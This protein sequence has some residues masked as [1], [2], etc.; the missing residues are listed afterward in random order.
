MGI[1]GFPFKWGCPPKSS[2]LTRFSITKTIQRAWGSPIFRA[3]NLQLETLVRCFFWTPRK[4]RTYHRH[5][6]KKCWTSKNQLNAFTNWGT[7]RYISPINT[8]I[9]ALRK[10]NWTRSRT[11]APLVNPIV[12]LEFLVAPFTNRSRFCCYM[13]PCPE[14]AWPHTFFW[15][16]LAAIGAGRAPV[17]E[18]VRRKVRPGHFWFIDTWGICI[19]K[20]TKTNKNQ[21]ADDLSLWLYGGFLKIGVPQSWMV[22][23]RENPMNKWMRTGGTP[24]WR[25]GNL[26]VVHENLYIWLIHLIRNTGIQ[27][28]NH[29]IV[30]DSRY[31]YQTSYGWAESTNQPFIEILR[32][33]MEDTA[34]GW[35]S[36]VVSRIIPEGARLSAIGW[37]TWTICTDRTWDEFL[38]LVGQGHLW[39]IWK[40]IGMM[41]YGK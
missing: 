20:P 29:G 41:K 40:S 16:L 18:R 2:I 1:W 17:G 35:D 8:I 30:D 6:P 22:F 34:A 21:K 36:D 9:I 27:G 15:H 14:H 28:T 24:S 23:V 26:H 13:A 31:M 19:E 4:P 12:T 39:K 3:G 38:W 5:K 10:T 7:T 32:V 25:N 33:S 37:T 11:G